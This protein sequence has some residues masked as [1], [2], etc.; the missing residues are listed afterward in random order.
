L[1]SFQ[2]ELQLETITAHL[3][4]G[5]FIALIEV[6][7]NMDDWELIIFGKGNIGF[8][9]VIFLGENNTINFLYII[10]FT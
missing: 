7:L 10:C 3:L 1:S 6:K 5:V 4:Q 8:A 2:L 9:N